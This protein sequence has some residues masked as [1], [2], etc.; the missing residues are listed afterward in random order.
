[1][2]TEKTLILTKKNGARGIKFPDFR[3]SYKVTVI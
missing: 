3:L 1:M 2:E